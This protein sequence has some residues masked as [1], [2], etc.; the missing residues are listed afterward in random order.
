MKDEEIIDLFFARS[1]QGIAELEAKY[2]RLFCRLAG[3]ILANSQD[4]EECVNDAYLGVWN[5]IPPKRP[6]RLCAYACKIVRNLALKRHERNTAAK[7]N[8]QYDAAFEELEACLSSE[9]DPQQIC[10]G[11]ELT[12]L[13]EVFL[14]SLQ[15]KDRILFIRRYWFADSVTEISRRMDMTPGAVSVRLARTRNRLKNY[16]ERSGY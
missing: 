7:R 10:E 14:D 8:S 3:N 16:L 5:R 4:A 2:G 13:I 12:R 11:R 9:N 1:Q 6:D 15:Q